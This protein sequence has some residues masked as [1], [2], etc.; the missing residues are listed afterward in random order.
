MKKIKIK[1]KY[2]NMVK[3]VKGV[4]TGGKWAGSLFSL[5]IT[6]WNAYKNLEK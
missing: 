4:K 2:L 1:K 6:A 3:A 5:F